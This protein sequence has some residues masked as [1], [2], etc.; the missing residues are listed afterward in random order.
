[1]KRKTLIFMLLIAIALP[2]CTPAANFPGSPVIG[3]LY[4]GIQTKALMI[5]VDINGEYCRALRAQG[6]GIVKIFVRDSQTDTEKKLG[7]IDG[8]LIPGGFD[9]DP[10]R[11]H[12][13]RDAKIEVVDEKLDALEYTALSLAEKRKLPVLGICRGCQMLNV[14]H[15][16]SLY[17]DIPA[18][19]KGKSKV[20]HRDTVNLLVYKHSTAFYHDITLERQSALYRLVGRDSLKVNTY[21]HQGVRGLAPGFRIT[22][23]SADGFVEAIEAEG[24]RFIMGLQFHPE[25]II[26]D[27]PGFVKIFQAFVA[28][29]AKANPRRGRR[30]VIASD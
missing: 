18:Y 22:A 16:G 13:T 2:A 5:G 29:A 27:D 11:Y 23:R 24:G 17:Q 1:M 10:S 6:A 26:A 15:G 30:S 3:I 25:K 12:E 8:L 4:G 19:Y 28:E 9:V 21:H 7:S 14:Y 20:Q